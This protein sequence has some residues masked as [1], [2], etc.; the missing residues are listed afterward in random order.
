MFKRFQQI[1]VALSA[2]AD[3]HAQGQS[4]RL[5]SVM[6]SRLLRGAYGL[7]SLAGIGRIAKHHHLETS[8]WV[9][10][11]RFTAG[12]SGPFDACDLRHWIRLSEL[13][14][15]AYV[16][17][18]EILRLTDSEMSIASGYLSVT[19]TSAGKATLDGAV[20]VGREIAE[21]DKKGE[22][23]AE[24]EDAIAALEVIASDEIERKEG[25][26]PSKDALRDRLYDA[27]DAVPEGWMVRSART[28]PSNL[29]A[30]AG[31]GHAGHETPD[32][33]F[34]PNVEVGPGWV[35]IG[36]RR[37]VAP[38]DLRT[39]TAAAQGPVG[40]SSFLARPWVKAKRYFVHEDPHR[41][42]T[43]LKGPGIWPAEWRAFVEDGQVV[44]VSC[45]YGWIGEATPENAVVALDVREQAQKVADKA[46]ELGM[47]PRFMDVERARVSENPAIRSNA[48]IQAHLDHF[49]QEK[50]AFTLDFIETEEGLLMLEGG[51]ANTPFGGAHPCAFAGVGG[52]PFYGKKTLTM[53]VAFK[54]MPQV[55]IGDPKTW[56]D[57]DRSGCILDWDEVADLAVSPTAVFRP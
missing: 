9:T 43:P 26:G 40:G 18:K 27:M 10:I 13:A 30:L 44:G 57:G 54:N 56:E 39:V 20:K 8:S 28:G 42:E 32:V 2:K 51:P 49:G 5:F 31:S 16:P 15:V 21:A 48:D 45:Y 4:L 6:G 23:T 55:L 41:V 22:V 24:M 14:G 37:R 34:G 47:W 17:A 36:N 29:K 46:T 50:V 25:R 53:G 19:D 52:P 35:R 7:K 12:E 33:P 11:D 3:N 1:M 38:E